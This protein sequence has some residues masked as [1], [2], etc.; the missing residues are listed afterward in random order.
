M[1]LGANTSGTETTA[2]LVEVS[3][4]NL[5]VLADWVSPLMPNEAIPDI[6]HLIRAVYPERSIT[7][8]V[9]GDVFD[10]VGRNPLVAALRSVGY[11]PNRGENAIMSRGSL[12]PQIRTSMNGRRMLLVDE[13]ARHTLRALAGEYKFPV[14]PGGER[15]AEPE[16]GPDRTL[17]EALETLTLAMSK[18][19]NAALSAQTNAV[20]STGTRYLSALPR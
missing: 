12:S 9:P 16:R 15:G 8:W 18:P 10:Q 7:A 20:N 17:I 13:N 14:K 2:V 3:G 4:R 6:A 5:T 19:N 11:K 1:I